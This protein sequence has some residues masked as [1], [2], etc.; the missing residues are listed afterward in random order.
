MDIYPV[1]TFL[2]G[3]GS[4]GE[5]IASLEYARYY[6][7]GILPSADEGREIAADN[8][9]NIYAAGLTTSPVT[10]FDIIILKYAPTGQLLWTSY[11]DGGDGQDDYISD[12]IL[13]T[14]DHIYIVGTSFRAASAFDY[15]LIKYDY[16]GRKEWDA[17]YRGPAGGRDWA[18]AGAV[19]P[20]GIIAITGESQGSE[21]SVDYATAAFEDDGELLWVRRY[22]C[23]DNLEDYAQDITSDSAGNFYVT[24]FSRNMVQYFDY[25]TVKYSNDGREMWTE[26]MSNSIQ[27]DALAQLIGCDA[28]GNVYISGQ[29][30]TSND[31]YDIMTVKYTPDGFLEWSTIYDGSAHAND[32][33][34]D[35]DVDAAG[36]AYMSCSSTELETG[37]DVRLVKY[38]IQG[39]TQWTTRYTSTATSFDNPRSLVL[40]R[41]GQIYVTGECTA[42]EGASKHAMTLCF[43]TNGDLKWQQIYNTASSDIQ[44]ANHVT[45]DEKENVIVVGSSDNRMKDF[46]VLCY[47]A[48][49]SALW[50]Q[51]FNGEGGSDD[52]VQAMTIDKQNNIYLTGKSSSASYNYDFLT[53][54]YDQNGQLEWLQRFD[55]QKH[56]DD[57]P[58]ALTTDE[59]GNVYIAGYSTDTDTTA[60]YTVIK[61]NSVGILQWS[62]HYDGAGHADDFASGI[63]VDRSGNIYV[64]G[65][66]WGV[67]SGPDIATIKLNSS[68]EI[69][70]VKTF[71]GSDWDV[72]TAFTMDMAA[73]VYVTGT[74]RN[75]AGN[76]DIVIIKYNSGGQ[77]QWTKTYKGAGTGDDVSQAMAVDQDGNVHIT[78]YSDNGTGGFDFLTLKLN[79]AGE[80][81]WWRLY[82]DYRN[83]DDFGRVLALDGSGNVYVTGLSSIGFDDLNLVTLQYDA[84]GTEKWVEHLSLPGLSEAW[85]NSIKM[86]DD[87]NVYIQCVRRE[88]DIMNFLTV[89]YNTLGE[90]KWIAHYK[91][92]GGVDNNFSMMELDDLKNVYVCG[93]NAGTG[94]QAWNGIM[95]LKYSQKMT[96]VR[97]EEETVCSNEL[98]PNYPNPCNAT[99]TI[100]FHLQRPGR[101]RLE[102]Y[103]LLGEKIQTL[104]DEYKQTGM[105]QVIW[106]AQRIASGI[107]LVKMETGHF[108]EIRKLVLV[109]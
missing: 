106:N 69:M 95:L 47:S 84:T 11:Y 51:Q 31:T 14:Y 87:D 41:N 42:E 26:R 72:P 1:R 21:T 2:P 44:W 54:K 86:D 97:Q 19:S 57:I 59:N 81:Q 43:N 8:Q 104:C 46:F 109:K 20:S 33:L 88:G 65:S 25:L 90:E 75:A 36:N 103:N 92:E 32:Y 76:Q 71:Q 91:G 53:L 18:K 82:D 30:F 73:N 56:E 12:I 107:Y 38:D 101:V 70:W 62:R 99:T 52:W 64:T 68:G 50:D 60:D 48:D 108:V 67:S 6:R 49:G 94:L 5:E 74:T 15:T 98:E 23:P 10:G 79:S 100:P 39:H 37:Q 28:D 27:K 22:N 40:G 96:P 34:S 63:R 105:H 3:T 55:D 4:C 7:S 9:G 35:F 78:G 83:E 45:M 93:T 17:H 85:I 13:D 80:T 16:D 58:L 77:E 24:G 102:I 61:Y 66:S 29:I 89:K